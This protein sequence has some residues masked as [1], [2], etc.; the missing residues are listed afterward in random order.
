MRHSARHWFKVR[1]SWTEILTLFFMATPSVAAVAVP[2]LRYLTIS[3]PLSPTSADA[4][5]QLAREF[6]VEIKRLSEDHDK[7]LQ[8]NAIVSGAEPLGEC[9]KPACQ[10]LHTSRD[11]ATAR[12]NDES[13]VCHKRFSK[14]L[15]DKSKAN[16]RQRD[17]RERAESESR[18]RTAR[19]T[20]ELDRRTPSA[21]A[22]GRVDRA[23][24]GN[25]GLREAQQRLMAPDPSGPWAHPIFTA[26]R[27]NPAAPTASPT[28]GPSVRPIE[29]A[30]KAQLLPD[31]NEEQK[32]EIGKTGLSVVLTYLAELGNKTIPTALGRGAG[33]VLT[34]PILDYMMPFMDPNNAGNIKKSIDA[35][36][37][38]MATGSKSENA[39]KYLESLER[40][41][42]EAW[43]PQS[44]P[45]R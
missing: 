4:C 22:G 20:V 17:L 7:C 44:P 26:P 15:A 29:S 10:A 45:Q 40:E 25:D 41:E 9:S 12:S 33:K 28:L 32:E 13:G 37:R 38:E 27:V 23:L 6:S 3:A 21:A 5:A 19:T 39:R 36:Y 34:L 16:D 24:P 18:E 2:S 35:Q 1:L 8:D 30:P 31:L 11:K 14:Y 42:A 43:R